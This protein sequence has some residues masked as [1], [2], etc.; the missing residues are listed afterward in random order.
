MFGISQVTFHRMVGLTLPLMAC[1]AAAEKSPPRAALGMP[2]PQG[3]RGMDAEER[4][5]EMRHDR[6]ARVGFAHVQSMVNAI[7]SGG[8]GC[9]TG[10]PIERS[11]VTQSSAT[12]RLPAARARSR[13]F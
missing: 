11:A 5:S 6:F 12:R 8:G 4:E 3:R 9:E 7:Y 2:M 13:S 1:A 10:A